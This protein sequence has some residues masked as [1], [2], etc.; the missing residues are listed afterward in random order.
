MDRVFPFIAALILARVSRD[1]GPDVRPFIAALILA[2]V[3]RECFFPMWAA[4]ILALVSE[5][6]C[7]RSEYGAVPRADRL[8]QLF[9]CLPML[10]DPRWTRQRQAPGIR[11][12]TR[13]IEVNQTII[14]AED[15]RGVLPFTLPTLHIGPINAVRVVVDPHFPQIP[16]YPLQ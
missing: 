4:L 10:V 11:R 8:V 12:L 2:R 16:R 1:L 6:I 13:Q 3:S 15:V 7:S 14:P 9:C 5:F